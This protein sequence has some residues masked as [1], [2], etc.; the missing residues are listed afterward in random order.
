MVRDLKAETHAMLPS[1][2]DTVSL[3]DMHRKNRPT[4]ACA[5][6]V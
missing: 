3:K 4:A 5:K 2:V 1:C 6:S